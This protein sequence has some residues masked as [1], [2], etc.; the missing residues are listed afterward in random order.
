MTYDK[1]S[2]K[3]IFTVNAIDAAE[4]SSAYANGEWIREQ[5]IANDKVGPNFVGKVNQMLNEIERSPFNAETSGQKLK[6]LAIFPSIDNDRFFYRTI[7]EVYKRPVKHK[8]IR[9]HCLATYLNLYYHL[10]FIVHICE[11]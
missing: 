2:F 7:Y 8:T 4:P 9:F 6:K 5:L 1:K 3:N 11:R 10:P